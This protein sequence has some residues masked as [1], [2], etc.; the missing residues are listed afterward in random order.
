M[1]KRE[2]LLNELMLLVAASVFFVSSASAQPASRI[3]FLRDQK[4]YIMDG[5]GKNL[6]RIGNL[7]GIYRGPQFSS[8]N[9]KVLFS[10]SEQVMSDA[11]VY[12]MNANGSDPRALTSGPGPHGGAQ[13]TSDGRIVYGGQRPGELYIMDM[14]GSRKAPY[15]VEA[16]GLG[17]LGELGS[18]S[19]GPG[20]VIVFTYFVVT[21]EGPFLEQIFK[22]SANGSGLT[23]LTNAT[24][25]YRL[26]GWCSNGSK[27]VY[28]NAGFT[29][30]LAKPQHE[31][32]GIYVMNADGTKASR[33]VDVDFSREVGGPTSFGIGPGRTTVQLSAEPSFSRDCRMVTFSMNL[34]D[35]YQIYVVNVDG[36]GLRRLTD[37]PTTN[38][39]P[40]FS[41]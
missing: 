21:V 28:M 33:I 19:F 8:D 41:R 38:S 25:T 9:Q 13:F 3:M 22:M 30:A 23:R 26:P 2:R 37:P 34:D 4:I 31:H 39:Q 12:I 35:N 7:P 24:E 17:K 18:F 20:G 29:Q 15:S 16:P 11:Q 6:R 5:D 1:C 27:I 40:V 10:Y 32:D 36:S 14:D